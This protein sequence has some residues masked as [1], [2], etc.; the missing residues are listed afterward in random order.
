MVIG[1]LDSCFHPLIFLV[2]ITPDTDFFRNIQ[3]L[4]TFCESE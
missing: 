2:N 3:L 4:W 1:V